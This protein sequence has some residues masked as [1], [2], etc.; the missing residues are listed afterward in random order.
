MKAFKGNGYPQSFIHS[1]SAAKAPREHDGE[2]E[3]E[4]PPIVHLPYIAGVS[5]RIRR[6]CRDFT[7]RVVFKSRPTIRSLLTKVKD[8]L[9]REKEAPGYC[10]MLAE[11]CS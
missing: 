9:P 10:S 3:E 1:A 5:E 4:R 2:R 6:V 8:P 11:L 7:I